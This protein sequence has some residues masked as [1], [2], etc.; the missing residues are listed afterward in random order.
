M[1]RPVGRRFVRAGREMLDRREQE[2]DGLHRQSSESGLHRCHG[3]AA[4]RERKGADE[5]S[6][7][8]IY[9]GKFNGDENSLPSAEHP[10]GAV[11]F[12]EFEDVKAMAVF[13][14][15]LALAL[16]VLMLVIL[17]LRG[18]AGHYRFAGVVL[19]LL[20]CYPHEILHGICFKETAYIYTNLKQG[21]LFVV[22]PEHMT[23]GR[24]VF[25]SLLPN[26]VFGFIPFGLFLIQP[27]WD[28]LGTMGAFAIGMGAGD[29]YNVFN[30]LT[31]MPKGALTYLHKFHSYW[32]LPG[33]D[34]TEG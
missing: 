3:L 26:L 32:Y 1:R 25:M 29:Y 13:A 9:K 19:A 7:K 4:E 24:F 15:G 14:N 28:I 23:K 20:S 27:Q 30:A 6:M 22:G 2:L 33:I 16:I 11:R 5:R 17:F 8:L 12:K 18:G 21:M 31:Q 10:A 34:E